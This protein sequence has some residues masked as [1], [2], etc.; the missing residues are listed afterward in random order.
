LGSQISQFAE[1]VTVLQAE[2]LEGI[3]DNQTLYLIV[4]GWDTLKYLETFQSS[5]S[6]WSFMWDHAS[7]SAPEDAR[8]SAEFNGTTAAVSDG[9]LVQETLEFRLLSN[10]AS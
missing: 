7:D 9:T 4:W 3:W 6:T 1:A 8:W 10:H 2:D 5:S